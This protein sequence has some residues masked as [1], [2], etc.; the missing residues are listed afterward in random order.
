MSPG[1]SGTV[2]SVSGNSIILTGK[3]GTTYTV[4]S[5]NAAI[6]KITNGAKTTITVSQIA[7]GDSL[8]VM[9]TVSGTLSYGKNYC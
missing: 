6:T 8:R 1:V 4:D 7:N 2:A 5:T 3:N 9:G